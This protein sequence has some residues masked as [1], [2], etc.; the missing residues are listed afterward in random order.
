[1]ADDEQVTRD[2]VD[3]AAV[4]IAERDGVTVEDV[5]E[6]VRRG[7]E[8]AG[9]ER[10]CALPGCDRTFTPRNDLHRFCKPAHRAA[11]HRRVRTDGAS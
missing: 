1:V 2:D 9:D 6:R 4:R 11:G 8:L 7:G 3:A 10:R 5:R